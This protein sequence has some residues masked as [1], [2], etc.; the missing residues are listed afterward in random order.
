MPNNTLNAYKA[1]QMSY[2]SYY[3]QQEPL[4]KN[5]LNQPK[6]AKMEKPEKTE[7]NQKKKKKKKPVP[8]LKF[9][10]AFGFLGRNEVIY[11]VYNA[12]EE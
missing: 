12:V 10:V 9:A 11:Y 7:K 8:N 6:L 3:N 5:P 2:K 1:L 4:N